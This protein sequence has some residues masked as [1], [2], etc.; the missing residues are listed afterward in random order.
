[1]ETKTKRRKVIKFGQDA[2]VITLPKDFTNKAGIK[3]GD[4]VGITYDSILVIVTPKNLKNTK[5]LNDE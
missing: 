4:I 3:V 2:M 1:M 5:L